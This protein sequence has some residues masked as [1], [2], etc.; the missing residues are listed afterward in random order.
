VTA[1]TAVT[2]V[3]VVAVVTVVTL[4]WT[5]FGKITHCAYVSTY[6]ACWITNALEGLTLT[7]DI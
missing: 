6:I 5:V 1:E 7:T 3:N 4:K 2:V